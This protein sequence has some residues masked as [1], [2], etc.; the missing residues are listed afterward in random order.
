MLLAARMNLRELAG[1]TRRMATALD[2]GLDVR[3]V[4]AREVEARW[5]RSLR[6]PLESV[7]R[8]MAS[9]SSLHDAI[10]A[11]GEVFP[12]LFRELITVGEQTGHLPE[13]FRRLAVHYENQLRLRRVF[14]AA[15]TWP[16]LQ[17]VSAV[18]I[19]GF[20]IWV[21]GWIAQSRGT[22]AV[23]I[24]GLG[25]TGERGAMIW[26]LSVGA[27]AVGGFVAW[28]FAARNRAVQGVAEAVAM[29]VPG[30]GRALDTLALAR[31]AWTL[32]LT[33]NTGMPLTQAVTMSLR[34]TR[35]ARY[36]GLTDE[37]AADIRAGHELSA[38]LGQTR[39][40]PREFLESL[41]VGERSGR[42]PESMAALA[43][44]YEERAGL[45]I[46]ALT[47]IAGFA[48]WALVAGLIIVLIFRMFF[49]Y[50]DALN[51]AMG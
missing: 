47:T 23:D 41:E 37:V 34:A 3:R 32:E 42:V 14:W 40:F 8:A 35:L 46:A 11:T 43:K 31:L 28:R 50:L 27:I 44:Q 7:R 38:S 2:A 30:L 18:C 17:L 51:S 33:T 39:R 22:E 9:G 24:F 26:F 36:V 10:D 48:V 49:F 16:L 21:L 1:F 45:A 13:V 25:L 4:W 15:I 20:V 12:P 5:P 19:V 6:E 29:Q